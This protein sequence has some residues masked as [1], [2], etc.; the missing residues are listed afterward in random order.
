VTSS[1]PEPLRFESARLVLYR[2]FDVADE[3]RLDHA[4]ELLAGE[5]TRMRLSR[6]RSEYLEIPRAPLTV[7]LGPRTLEGSSGRKFEAVAFARLF[8][9]G[10]ISIRYEVPLPEDADSQVAAQLVHE[11][12]GSPNVEASARAEAERLR[13]RLP[14]ALDTPHVWAV[15]ETY[16]VLLAKRVLG[17]GVPSGLGCDPRIARILL[18][19]IGDD[20]LSAEEVRDA[21]QHR[22][23]YTEQDLCVVDWNA[24]VVIEPQP[25]H[26]ILD[27]LEFATAQ[28]LEFRFYDDIVDREMESLYSMIMRPREPF[29]WKLG[30]RYRRLGRKLNR[31][32]LETVEFV[33][34][35]DNSLKVIADSY[36]ARIYQ[37]AILSFRVPLWQASVNRKQELVRQ[38]NEV[39]SN[40]SQVSTSHLLELIVILLILYE[41]VAPIVRGIAGH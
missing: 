26:D 33:E 14:S 30:G 24:A 17:A 39:L 9:F 22:F 29:F 32:L 8:N 27:I 19:E 12:E 4:Q 1:I 10:V 31:R 25:S 34:R 16:A 23:S 37:G 5:A 11:F 35:V 38:V 15:V 3:I 13:E 20:P 40:E 6:E 41:I 21:T 28:L 7:H 2:L 18:A 36:L